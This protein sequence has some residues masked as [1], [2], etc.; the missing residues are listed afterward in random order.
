VLHAAAILGKQFEKGSQVRI[1]P[2]LFTG[3]EPDSML[4][5]QAGSRRLTVFTRQEISQLRSCIEDGQEQ[6]LL[7]FLTGPNAEF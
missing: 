5:E 2:A 3:Q 7:S 6:R 4:V 1:I